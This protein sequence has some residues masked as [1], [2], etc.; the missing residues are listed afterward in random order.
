[1]TK[2]T[3]RFSTLHPDGKESNVRMLKQ[4]DIM[5]CPHVIFMPE[6]YR[7]D[8]TCKCDDPN[9]TVMKEWGYRWHAGKKQWAGD[10]D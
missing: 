7:D 6:H 2:D 1:M 8:G 9:E 10:D 3:I 4:S 5:K